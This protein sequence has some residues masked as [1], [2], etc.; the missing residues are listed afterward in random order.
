MYTV[1][2]NAESHTTVGNHF[3]CGCIMLEVH[4]SGCGY[5]EKNIHSQ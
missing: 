3:E 2:G 4:I 5:A 1:R